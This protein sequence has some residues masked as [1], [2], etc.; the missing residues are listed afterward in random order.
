MSTHT[1]LS[2]RGTLLALLASCTTITLVKHIIKI[3]FLHNWLQGLLT[4][5]FRLCYSLWIN[6]LCRPAHFF[7]WNL[8]RLACFLVRLL[9]YICIFILR[10]EEYFG[11]REPV[12]FLDWHACFPTPDAIFEF[13]PS[14]WTFLLQ[15]HV[16]SKGR[17]F[18][19]RKA[20]I[21]FSSFF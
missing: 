4:H 21:L 2:A 10:I 18:L 1:Y 13:Y 6:N 11:F 7:L 3:T 12:A 5:N 15:P 17:G 19:H 8:S 20:Y 9:I 16:H 14:T